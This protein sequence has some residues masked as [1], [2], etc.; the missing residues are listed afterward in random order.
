M[1]KFEDKNIQIDINLTDIC[2]DYAWCNL[3]WNSSI[4]DNI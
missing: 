4:I 3:I 1:R 2:N